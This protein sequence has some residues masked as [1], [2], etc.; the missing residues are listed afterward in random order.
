MSARLLYVVN[1]PRFFVSHRLPLA[2]AARRA[3]YEVHVATA[4]VDEENLR[5]IREHGLPLHLLPLEQ[6]GTNT[7]REVR[8]LLSLVVLLVRLRP[9]LLHLI[10]IKPVIYGGIAARLTRRRA[11]IAA[12]S[13]LGRVFRDEAGRARTPSRALR[14]ALRVALP[15]R[16]SHMLLQNEDDRDALVSLGVVDRGSTS[17]IPGSGVD[18][19]RFRPSPR[20]T[21]HPG[22][23]VFLYAGRLMWQKGLGEFIEVAR[24]LSGRA[25][26]VVAGYSEDGSP[27]AVPVAQL[28]AW[29]AEG[30]IEWLGSRTDMPEVIAGSDVVVLPTV[31]GEGV[32]KVLIEAAASGRAIVTTD[33]PGCRDICRDG[34]NGLLVPPADVDALERSLWSLAQDDELREWMGAAGRNVAEEQFGLDQVLERSLAL[35]SAMLGRG[36]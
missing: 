24:R 7:L 2:L 5:I 36:R 11:V 4:A 34:V 9:D 3:G 23:A 20:S 27:D 12:M 33:T 29:A 25:R 19:D 6:H 35:Y 16:S 21:E 22:E 31:Y 13:G 30:L 10:T 26:F 15:R 17:V 32:P 8:T 14:V 18:L 1:I 28:E